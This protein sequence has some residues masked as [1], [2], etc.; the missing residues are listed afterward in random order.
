M[1]IVTLNDVT[2]DITE[3]VPKH[4]GGSVIEAAVGIDGTMLFQ[5]RRFAFCAS[6]RLKANSVSLSLSCVASRRRTTWASRWCA[7]RPCW[8]SCRA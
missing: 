1:L 5:A 8:R 2:Y 4:P 7:R 3:W 6:S